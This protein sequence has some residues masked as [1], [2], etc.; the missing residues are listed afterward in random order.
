VTWQRKVA[1][2]IE[3]AGADSERVLAALSGAGL[4]IVPRIPTAEM[5]EDAWDDIH[6]EDGPSAWR[7]MIESFEARGA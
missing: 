6:E 3:S 2:V 1:H 7:D 5:L 4:V